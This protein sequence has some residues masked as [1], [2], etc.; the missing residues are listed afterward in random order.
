MPEP[1]ALEEK[2]SLFPWFSGETAVT[3]PLWP[4]GLAEDQSTPEFGFYV[5]CY[6]PRMRSRL[7]RDQNKEIRLN[8]TVREIGT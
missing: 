5:S 3:V 6:N 4:V 7:E 2:G 8:E 1:V